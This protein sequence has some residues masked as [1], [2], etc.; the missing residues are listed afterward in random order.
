LDLN[1]EFYRKVLDGLYDGVYF[2]DRDR[3]IVYWNHGAE[4]LTGFSAEEV[5]GS[6]CFDNILNH[7]DETGEWLCKGDCPLTEAMRTGEPQE[8]A[9]FLHHKAGHRVPVSIRAVPM[10]NEANEIVGAAEVFRDQSYQKAMLRKMQELEKMALLDPL[11]RLANRQHTE[12]TLQIRLDELSRYGWPFGVLFIDIDHFKP[13]NDE[14]GH[15]VGDKVLK[16]VSMTLHNSLRPFDFLGRWG[17]EE[18]LAIIVNVNEDQLRHVANRSR[19]LV[20]QSRLRVGASSAQVTI[21]I[22]ATMARSGDSLRQLVRRADKL[23]YDSKHGG[24]NKVTTE[25]GFPA[26]QN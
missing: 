16:L 17:G 26:A 18:F 15:E 14:H 11:T 21:S 7:V 3:K 9:V 22:G 8:A 6:H 13:F 4:Q 10:Y 25:T 2:V 12:A 1:S 19:G 24:R 23:M 5:L 20:A